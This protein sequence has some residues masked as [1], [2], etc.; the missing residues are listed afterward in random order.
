MA[1]ERAGG[2]MHRPLRAGVVHGTRD[3]RTPFLQRV[4]ECE[5]HQA[6]IRRVMQ[7]SARSIHRA[8]LVQ[9]DGRL[10]DDFAV[11]VDINGETVGYL[12]EVKAT[13]WRTGGSPDMCDACLKGSVGHACVEVWLRL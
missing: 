9:D 1:R 7:S 2:G 3:A 8:R 4:A 5:S 10:K 13:G 11:R 12:P 6:A